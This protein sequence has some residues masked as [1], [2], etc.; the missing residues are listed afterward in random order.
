ML[1]LERFI[2]LNSVD[3][4]ELKEIVRALKDFKIVK[5]GNVSSHSMLPIS[6]SL[7]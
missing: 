5:F 2:Q 7:G 4:E 1:R 3:F 6:I